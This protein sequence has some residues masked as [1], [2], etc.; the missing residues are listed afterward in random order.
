[1]PHHKISI[2]RKILVPLLVVM[3]LQAGVVYGL[4]IFGGTISQMRANEFDIFS[5]Q[6]SSRKD[7]LENEMVQRWSNLN[8][9]VNTILL[10]T[11]RVLAQS[12]K[13]HTDLVPQADVTNTL[14][15]E[16]SDDIIYLL[17]KN[18][19]SGAFIVL[20]GD[21]GAQKSGVYFRDS[22]PN[23]NPSDYS[24]LLA[25]RAPSSL[26]KKLGIALDS[27]WQPAFDLGDEQHPGNRFFYKPFQAAKQY[28]TANYFDLGYW[29]PPFYLA[30]DTPQLISYSVPLVNQ[31]GAVFGV[32]GVE[33]S[34]DYLNR[35]IPAQELNGGQ[36][37]CYLLGIGK[38]SE[39]GAP[40]QAYC[41][42]VSNGSFFKQCF[43][44]ETNLLFEENGKAPQ[45]LTLASASPATEP[46]F[47]YAHPLQLYNNNT[48]FEEDQWT[49]V[50][51][52]P[53]SE[54]L[55][56]V[57]Q[58]QALILISLL[59]STFVGI[60]GIFVAAKMITRPIGGLSTKLKTHSAQKAIV[61]DRIKIVEIDEL[62]DSIETLSHQVFESSSKLSKILELTGVTTGAFEL[63][64]ANP[65]HV[66]CTSGFFDI[67]NIPDAGLTGNY[68]PTAKF[69]ELFYSISKNV[70]ESSEDGTCHIFKIKHR[71]KPRW[72]RLK[73]VMNEEGVL[74]AVTDVTQEI[75]ERKRIE[76]DRDYDLLT[77]LFNRRAFYAKMQALF[78]A[79]DQLNYCAVLMIDLDNLKFVN[80][81]YGHDYGD[82]YLR[83]A[84]SVLKKHCGSQSVVARLSGDE[85]VVLLYGY[86]HKTPIREI[87]A[88]IQEGMRNKMIFFPD[89]TQMQIRASAGIAWYPD[90]SLL[91]E[92]LIRYAD[93][94][95][96]LVKKTHKG[97]F[98][99]FNIESYHRK[100]YLLYCREELNTLIDQSLIRFQFQPILDA[101]TGEIFAF[102]ALMRPQT[103]NIKTPL[104]LL[105]L[106]RSQSKL[107]QIER[108]TFF[109]AL[110]CFD[111]LPIAKS[112]CKLF[113]NSISN[114]VVDDAGMDALEEKFGHY[115]HRVVVEMTEEE[116]VSAD[117][118]E[119]KQ[120]RI[121][122][123]GAQV[124]LDD[125][126][127][128]YNG[129]ALLLT[130]SPQYIKLDISIVQ[131]VHIDSNRLYLMNNLIAYSKKHG[132]K[133]I[134][135]GVECREELEA[136]I[137]AG[138][139]YLQGYY[140]CKPTYQP[141]LMLE[142]CRSEILEL[143][144]TSS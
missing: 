34:T 36:K 78:A 8:E 144:A 129:E 1:M 46:V 41:V 136:L 102:E 99:E 67:L 24:D 74:G 123:W 90:D 59:F 48:P 42:A 91:Y 104:E 80:D 133:V 143:N 9:S 61:L 32:L 11:N 13:H 22:D 53:K 20:N 17:R 139:D 6:I 16:L 88:S 83:S 137:H 81:T 60:V 55:A 107:A 120:A 122:K 4:L 37:D 79:P 40:A 112:D 63:A 43:T 7:L 89:H 86:D 38:K 141:E 54:L 85:F 19:V 2:L 84:A 105:S 142:T 30:E 5:K 130:L 93:F 75:L 33:I 82:E 128:G 51:M 76:Y 115:L 101:H 95:M 110:G 127:V 56:S 135:E 72:V 69:K 140:L 44:G 106:A 28:P 62:L 119:R 108:L 39:A 15:Y 100:S 94:A 103:A 125:F 132:I 45:M 27:F 57:E 117:C 138:V 113:I 73:L 98:T 3:S 77:S 18:S 97:E 64:S 118:M 21:G 68:L 14:L 50:G 111:E 92:D 71:P 126:G 35:Y 131:N 109:A 66:F 121:N 12:N 26:T 114:Q 29:C 65:D 47:A 124:A 87:C 10:Q 116:R 134:A 25:E 52:L 70:E 31:N 49:L 58:L 23:S 96:Y